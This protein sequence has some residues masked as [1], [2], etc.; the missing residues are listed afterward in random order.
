MMTIRIL[1]ILLIGTILSV[2]SCKQ[3]TELGSD[4]V[5]PDTVQSSF[6]G[7]LTSVVHTNL[8]WQVKTPDTLSDGSSGL[9]PEKLDRFASKK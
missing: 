5:E 3:P 7:L 9:T 1:A 4:Y 6:K 8:L 2:T